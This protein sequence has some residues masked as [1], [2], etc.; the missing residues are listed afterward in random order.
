MGTLTLRGTGPD[1]TLFPPPLTCPLG[2]PA[3]RG[4]RHKVWAYFGLL[5]HTAGSRT[6][7]VLN[8]QSSSLEASSY[9]VCPETCTSLCTKHSSTTVAP[10]SALSTAPVTS[11]SF[12]RRPRRTD[13]ANAIGN[14]SGFVTLAASS[15]TIGWQ[16]VMN[17]PICFVFVTQGSVSDSKVRNALVLCLQL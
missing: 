6:S 15:S 11:S 12:H 16:L 2:P 4:H 14:I 5:T 3:S 7:D 17:V 8:T 10:V 13:V 9:E 1:S